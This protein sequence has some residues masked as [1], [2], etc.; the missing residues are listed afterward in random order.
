MCP[1][2]F[3]SILTHVVYLPQC[4]IDMR[5]TL[6]ENILV[7]GGTSIMPGFRHRL[8]SELH[9]LLTVAPYNQS[10]ALKKFKFH[11]APAK[12]N[13]TAWLGG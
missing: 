13:F 7:V 10:L 8:L 12:E 9:D 1:S 2:N 5:K 4:P 3:H 11:S 6:A